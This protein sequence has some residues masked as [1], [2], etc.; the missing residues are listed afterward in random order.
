[1]QLFCPACQAAFAGTQRCPRCGGLLLLPQEAAEAVVPRVKEA[2]PAPPLPSPTS[3]VVVG[4]VLALGM[5]LA[6]RKF[7]MGALMASG[8]EPEAWW[9]TLDGLVAVCGAQAVAVVLGAVVAAAGRSGGFLFGASVGGL[10]GVLFL[11]AELVG[12]AAGRGQFLYA[13]PLALAFA[14]SAAGAVAARVWGGVP[15]LSLR[16]PQDKP[17]GPLPLEDKAEPRPTSWLRI[18]LGAAFVVF[19]VALTDDLRIRAQRYSGGTLHVST[20]GEGHFLSWQF[21]VLG[22]ML[23]GGIAAG[24]TGAGFR[25]GLI[26]GFLASG[27]VFVFTRATGLDANPSEYLLNTLTRLG[28]EMSGPIVNVVEASWVVLFATLGGW[29]GGIAVPPLAPEHMR[30]KLRTGLD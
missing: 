11:G 20:I 12:G 3:R 25:H 8:R 24:G 14:G 7:L 16:G 27:G 29:L 28:I 26:A 13:L 18:I 10:C 15:A 5:Y 6:L 21:A 9:L 19:V 23:G 1:M 4:C 2:P 30:Q 22:V 17:A